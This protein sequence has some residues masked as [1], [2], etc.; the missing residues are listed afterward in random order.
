[1]TKFRLD[2]PASLMVT[3]DG[4]TEEEAI[5][6]AK[7]WCD[8]HEGI[9]LDDFGDI[10][11]RL[12]PMPSG[13]EAEQMEAKEA[14]CCREEKYREEQREQ[15]RV[16]MIRDAAE[17]LLAMCEAMLGDIRLV[18]PSRKRKEKGSHAVL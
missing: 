18:L 14:T 3:F 15:D 6:A 5:A 7:D 13:T 1:M 10:E 9:G 16:N 11:A 12:Y 2:I 17:D 4:A 8:I